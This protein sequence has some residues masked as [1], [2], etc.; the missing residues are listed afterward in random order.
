MELIKSRVPDDPAGLLDQHKADVLHEELC[1][2]FP[3]I[4]GSV[5]QLAANTYFDTYDL[6]SDRGLIKQ[7]IKKPV[8]RTGSDWEKYQNE[9]KS[10]FGDRWFL[11]QDVVRLISDKMKGDVFK[12]RMS[13]KSVMDKHNIK[14]S[15]ICSSVHLTQ[16]MLD[17]AVGHYDVFVG[18]FQSKTNLIITDDV[19]FARLKDMRDRWM[20]VTRHFSHCQG[21]VDLNNDPTIRLAI[22]IINRH[23][24]DGDHLNEA[25][26]LAM[27]LNTG[28][29]DVV[30]E[31][32]KEYF[33]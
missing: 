19:K 21:I 3:P 5:N 33:T 15:D 13:I 9:A 10:Y 7:S 2:R 17:L 14:D 6:L 30:N 18:K 28:L 29:K 12:L 23:I 22:K 1:L 32:Y 25:S 8:N 27:H 31:D 20:P 4:I 16:T 11:L 24:F 26:R